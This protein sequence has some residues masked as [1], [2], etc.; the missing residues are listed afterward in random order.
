MGR[1]VAVLLAAA[2]VAGGVEGQNPEST[3]RSGLL[4]VVDSV[5]DEWTNDVAWR[6][7]GP[8]VPLGLPG[9]SLQVHAHFSD[10]LDREVGQPSCMAR[11]AI[12]RNRP[13]RASDLEWAIAGEWRLKVYLRRGSG[14]AETLVL[15]PSVDPAE[16]V[17][18]YAGGYTKPPT[19]FLS[20]SMPG[21]N[22]L[23][24]M[25]DTTGD[26]RMKVADGEPFTLS[27]EAEAL[28]KAFA[29]RLANFATPRGYG[30]GSS[31]WC[32]ASLEANGRW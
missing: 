23:R 12:V 13:W 32:G 6:L 14:T 7:A 29:D 9:H 22:L 5:A 26:L 18:A 16:I 8:T 1:V 15:V 31:P 2:W 3:D 21:D 17:G 30:L 24:M 4:S 10:R 20:E 27:A 11:I 19:P 28:L 25:Q